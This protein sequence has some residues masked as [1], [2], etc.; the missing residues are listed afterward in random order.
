MLFNSK[1]FSYSL[2]VCFNLCCCS[3]FPLL[4]KQEIQRYVYLFRL[5][6]VSCMWECAR[7]PAG[8]LG[9]VGGGLKKRKRNLLRPLSSLIGP[10][11]CPSLPLPSLQRRLNLFF[12]L[13][14]TL[15]NNYAFSSK[16]LQVI[17]LSPSVSA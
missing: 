1:Q 17:F 3:F 8:G 5:M 11:P 12:I 7:A 16:T 6:C 9:G 13:L 14:M 15:E 4:Y 2:K 10:S